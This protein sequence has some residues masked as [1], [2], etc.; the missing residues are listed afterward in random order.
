[1]EPEDKAEALQTEPHPSIA[2][3]R[4]VAHKPNGECAYLTADGCSIH[5]HAPSLCQTADCRSVAARLDFDAA[6][7]LHLQGRLDLRVWDKGR[8]LLED[9]VRQRS[10]GEH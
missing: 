1:L 3:A 10:A 5:D 4:M 8:M 7:R 9:L 2:G 6:R